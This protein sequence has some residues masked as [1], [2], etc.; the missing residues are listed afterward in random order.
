MYEKF[1]L[2]HKKCKEKHLIH[3]SSWNISLHCSSLSSLTRKIM[4][5]QSFLAN[6]NMSRQLI[7]NIGLL[8]SFLHFQWI[9]GNI[10]ESHGCK[11]RKRVTC[12][13]FTH[14]FLHAWSWFWMYHFY[15]TKDN[16]WIHWNLWHNKSNNNH[17][18]KESW[19]CMSTRLLHCPVVTQN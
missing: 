5:Q 1:S 4:E 17:F 8:W 16:Y 10:L 7:S 19:C 13:L 14:V 18:V 2:Y 6:T 11:L 3:L 12:S 9:M 15:F